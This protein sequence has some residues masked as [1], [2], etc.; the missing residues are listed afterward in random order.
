MQTKA[1]TPP[2]QDRSLDRKDTAVQHPLERLTGGGWRKSILR[3]FLGVLLL[4]MVLWWTGT[5]V[6]DRLWQRDTLPLL[7]AGVCLSIL[8]RALRVCKWTWIVSQS[9]LGEYKLGYLLRIQYVGLLINLLAPLSE[10]MK[11]WAI[12]RTRKHVPVAFFTLVLD[13]TYLGLAVAILGMGGAGLVM[14]GAVDA[15]LPLWIAG[16]AVALGLVALTIIFFTRRWLHSRPEHAKIRKYGWMHYSAVGLAESVC[17]LGTFAL[18]MY[19]VGLGHSLAV[20]AAVYPLLF[21]SHLIML[22]PS[23]LGMR[24]AIFAAV[25]ASVSE[26]PSQAAVAVGLMVSAMNL[27]TAVLAGSTALLLPGSAVRKPEP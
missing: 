23:G 12:S 9:G 19:A 26:E 27:A 16:F 4:S 10:T 1:D 6:I 24:E 25:F 5:E 7:L 3:L 18:A 2:S 17:I 13:T 21:F 20:L 15:V 11:I 14:V 8:Q 22:T